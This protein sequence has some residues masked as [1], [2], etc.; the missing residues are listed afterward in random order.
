MFNRRLS[1]TTQ[2]RILNFNQWTCYILLDFIFFVGSCHSTMSF[3]LEICIIGLVTF[4]QIWHNISNVYLRTAWFAV[5][6]VGRLTQKSVA[7][8][9]NVQKSFQYCPA[10]TLWIHFPLNYSSLSGKSTVWL[11]HMNWPISIFQNST[12]NNSRLLGINISK[13]LI[14]SFKSFILWETSQVKNKPV[15][16]LSLTSGVRPEGVPNEYITYPLVPG[17]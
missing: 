5:W 7:V 14:Q 6:L 17:K 13:E 9:W 16:Y 4:E 3:K 10:L 8:C 15:I 2:I 11:P 1:K 12:S